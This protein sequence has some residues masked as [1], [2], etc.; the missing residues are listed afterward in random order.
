[1]SSVVTIEPRRH[2]I[3]RPIERGRA[4][5]GMIA[6]IAT[7]AA[8][9]AALFLSYWY[10][11]RGRLSWPPPPLEPPKLGL[12]SLMTLLLLSSSAALQ[13]A[14]AGIRA[15]NLP[16]L[17]LGLVLTVLLG[18]SFLVT[19]VFEYRDYLKH[20]QPKS[21]AYGSIFY[22]ITSVHGAHVLVGVLMLCY[23]GLQARAALFTAQRHQAVR[24]VSWY[25]HFV[26]V[27][28]IGIFAMLYIRP[29]V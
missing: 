5:L 22:L 29:H 6:F 26:D 18:G 24:L 3:V 10:L 7:E 23:V 21:G 12:A 9:F 8:L 4:A 11:S 2:Q 1:M 28:W 25:W 19:Q 15:G 20:V 16:R 27:V 13:W 14:G 17:R